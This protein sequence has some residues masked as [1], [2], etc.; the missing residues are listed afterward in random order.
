MQQSTA[1]NIYNASAGSGK[2]FTLVKEYLKRILVSKNEGFYKN[3]LAITFTNKAVAEM[4]QRIITNLVLF[5]NPEALSQPPEMLLQ[6]SKETALSIEYIHQQSQKILK[7]LLHHYAGF[8]VET[9]DRFNHQ[10]I[11][12]FARDLKLPQNFEVSLDIGA[13][14]AEAVD[15]LVNKAGEDPEITKVL[16]DFAME[17]TDDDKS[18]DITKDIALAAQILANENDAPHV[19]KLRDRTLKDFVVFKK[20][21]LLQKNEIAAKIQQKASETIQLIEE[22]G[23]QFD[24]FSSSYL[25]KH[26]ANLASGAFYLNFSAK[27]QETMGEKPLYPGRVAKDTPEIIPV[28]ET[29]TPNFIENFEITKQW[30]YELSLIEAVLKNITPLSVI[31]L[32]QQELQIIKEEQAILPISEFNSLINNEI[33][34]QPAPFIYERLGEKYRHFFIDEFQDTSFMQWQNLIPLIDN[35]LSQQTFDEEQGSLLLVGDAKQ[36][37]YRWRGGLPEQFIALCNEENPFHSEKT[38]LNLE[39]NFRSCKNIIDFNNAFF[40]L[41]APYFDNVIHANLYE[42][43]N[44][45]FSTQKHGGYVK[46]EFV[47]PENKAEAD[48]L[49]GEL[50]HNTL[51]KICDSEFTLQDVCILTRTKKEGIAIGAY[52]ME[53]NILIIS[54]ETLLLQS[55]PVVQCLVDA[56]TLALY[57]E[58]EEVKINLLGFL[59]HHFQIAEAQHTFFSQFLNRSIEEFEENL[60]SYGIDFK[61]SAMQSVSLYESCEYCCNQ[62]QLYKKSDGYLYGFM[63]FVFD[64]QQRPLAGKLAFLDHWESKKE[65][66]SIPAAITSEAVRIMTIHK[67][68]GLE[69]PVVIFPFADVEIYNERSA[70]TWFPW[71]NDADIFDE[72][73]INYKNDVANY[74]AVG[75]QVYRERRETLELDNLNLLYVALTR[76]IEQLYVF[77]TLPKEIKAEK[78]MSFNQFFAEFL[79]KEGKWDENS[80]T[81]EFGTSKR[82]LQP[83]IPESFKQ[84]APLYISSLPKE[85]NLKIV[86]A[87]A[88]LWDTAVEASITAGNLLHDT[89]AKIKTTED[90]TSVFEDLILQSV[91]SAE[92]LF[93]L[94]DAVSQITS[95]PMLAHL[96]DISATNVVNERDIIT[97]KGDLLRPDRLNFHENA[98]VTVVDYKT[99][100]PS[101]THKSQINRYASALEEMDFRISEKILVY[102]SEEKIMVNK[103]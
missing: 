77:A 32:V 27:W 89:M 102:A 92:E 10:L 73:Y 57:P 95:H 37:I 41:I 29:L 60:K 36:S 62:F 103:V 63:D 83:E 22:S 84:V 76:S 86:S 19:A 34:N 43:G 72:V 53:K 47:D 80:S 11:R 20:R 30:V 98:S 90:I 46:F 56:L 96:F 64:F 71:E 25:P 40:S 31:N 65:S 33:K 69:F 100:N 15:Q 94:K 78:P 87:E 38:V 91:V 2:T 45:Q 7:H 52:L 74:G 3:L 58:N 48:V 39:T 99:G 42:I 66:A 79:K 68:K 1:F 8:N 24:D 9:I 82:S 49:Y 35:A 6:I 59:H 67:A 17:K 16:L 28:I 4:K 61:I 23:L 50:V 101:E 13:L 55:S 14:I 85:H 81:A 70:K 75:E 54:S 44:R 97:S 88:L 26:F 93:K 12:T 51:Q 5:S 21:L 18:W